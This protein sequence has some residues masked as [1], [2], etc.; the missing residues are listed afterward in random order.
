MNR[1]LEGRVVVITGAATGIGQATAHCVARAG[2]RLVLGDVSPLA[3]ETAAAIR[4][5][6]GEA[7]FVKTD[8]SKSADVE[9]LIGEAVS[10]HGRIDGAFNNAGI[11]DDMRRTAEYSEEEFDRMISVNLRGVWLCLRAEINQMLKNGG[12]SIVSTASAAGLV[13]FRG[14]GPYTATKHGVVGL[15]KTSALEYATDGIRV[16]CVC[17][18]VIDTP[19]LKSVLD[20]GRVTRAQMEAFEPVGRMGKPSEI[21]DAVVWLLSDQ[22]SFVTGIALPVDGGFIAQ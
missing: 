13:G 2:G 18:G 10:C 22:S 8:V 3:E 9:R 15:T 14:E 5:E 17:P 6:G 20:T 4:K 21:G 1:S 16:N 12:G 19:M 7:R 11:A